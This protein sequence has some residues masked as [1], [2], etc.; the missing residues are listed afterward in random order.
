MRSLFDLEKADSDSKGRLLKF[1][2]EGD[3]YTRE[4]KAC[5]DGLP[6]AKNKGLTFQNFVADSLFTKLTGKCQNSASGKKTA[7]CVGFSKS[8]H[9]QLDLLAKVQIRGITEAMTAIFSGESS[10]ELG[11][12][13]EVKSSETGL[14]RHVLQLVAQLIMVCITAHNREKRSALSGV[15]IDAHRFIP[16][17]YVFSKDKDY[18]LVGESC[19]YVN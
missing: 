13:G 9:G 5:L 8:W 1:L 7:L 3:S 10:G 18:L 17:V 2:T 14:E 15:L 12:V 11:A 19:S 16:V 4:L 6:A